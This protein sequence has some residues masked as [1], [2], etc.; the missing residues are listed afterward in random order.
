MPIY[1]RQKLR[2]KLNNGCEK[3]KE[4]VGSTMGPKGQNVMIDSGHF[5][6]KPIITKDGVTVIRTIYFDDKVENMSLKVIREAS[7]QTLQECGDGTTSTSVL[8]S[9]IFINGLKYLDK[10]N[11]ILMKRG[12]DKFVDAFVKK[13]DEVKSELKTDEEIRNIAMVSSNHDESITNLITDAIKEVDVDGSIL[14]EKSNVR[15]DY[16][17]IESGYKIEKGMV[18]QYF[19]NSST[20]VVAEYENAY[21]ALFNF[22]IDNINDIVD[23]L[24]DVKAQNKPLVLIAHAFST[25]VIQVLIANKIKNNLKIL[26]IE[27]PGFGDRKD[28]N[29]MDIAMMTGSVIFGLDKDIK[30]YKLS[31]LKTVGK[32]KSTMNETI[33]SK[34]NFDE[35]KLNE[36]V[37]MLKDKQEQM[38]NEYDK[39][40]IND[41]IRKLKGK[42][43]I[44]RIYGETETEYEEKKDR[45]DDAIGATRSAIEDGILTGGSVSYIKI[46]ELIDIEELNLENDDEFQGVYLLAESLKDLVKM[47]ANNAGRNGEYVIEKIIETIDDLEYGYNAL[48]DKFENLV[49]KG[50][51][52]PAKVIKSVVK[53][54]V[55]AAGMLLTTNSLMIQENGN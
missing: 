21:I 48:E 15:K 55:S 42:T 19:I 9:S 30:E 25:E 7:E 26:P 52:D 38:E 33:L 43:A 16:L 11:P 4:I 41:R 18:S 28:E 31:E 22:E 24:S 51:I 36:Y 6:S 54:A 40:L 50:I 8:A 53:N 46:A 32:V 17:E 49:E 44:I 10:F 1:M 2:K 47:I 45:V 23:I 29:L 14:V 20:K 5:Y 35:E 13:V 12:M 34:L 37:D 3:I 27:T 39:E